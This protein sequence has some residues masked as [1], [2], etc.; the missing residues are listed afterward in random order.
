[1]AFVLGGHGPG[2][3]GGVTLSADVHPTF[4]EWDEVALSVIGG[5]GFDLY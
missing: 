4:Y 5:L 3:R 1:V 2:R